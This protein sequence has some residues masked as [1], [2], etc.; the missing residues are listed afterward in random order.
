MA[1]SELHFWLGFLVWKAE[2]EKDAIDE[3]KR[4][5]KSK[6]KSTGLGRV[7]RSR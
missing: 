5:G 7:N 2:K 4:K 1:Q 3:A 6:S